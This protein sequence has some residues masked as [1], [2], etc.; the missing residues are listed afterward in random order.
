VPDLAAGRVG[1]HRADRVSAAAG[2]V[3]ILVVL[4]VHRHVSRT[5]NVR[6]RLLVLQGSLLLGVVN[7]AQVVNAGI[8]LGRVARPD[9]VRD[10]DG[11]QQADDGDHN[12]DFHEGEA[13]LACH[14]HFHLFFSL[15][16]AA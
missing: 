7:L 11:G 12:H 4:D 6:I 5:G 3:R 10:R 13:R 8:L 15:S 2:A 16:V 1:I 14:S 9:E